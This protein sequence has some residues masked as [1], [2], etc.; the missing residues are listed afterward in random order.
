MT[1]TGM[2]AAQLLVG[3]A[4]T[5]VDPVTPGDSEFDCGARIRIPSAVSILRRSSGSVVEGVVAPLVV[6][7]LTLRWIDLRVA[8]LTTLVWSYLAVGRR[9]LKGE[10]VTFLLGLGTAMLTLRT[11]VSVVTNNAFVYFALPAVCSFG[12]GAY[13]SV[14]AVR[15][16][17]ATRRFV[18]DLC[19]LDEEVL[20]SSAVRRFM[21]RVSYLWAAALVIEATASMWLLLS[22]PVATFLIERTLVTWVITGLSAAGSAWMFQG[23]LRRNVSPCANGAHTGPHRR[24][25]M[26]LAGKR[27]NSHQDST[28]SDCHS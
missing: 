23:A 10:S 3:C 6:F 14:T 17:P 19:P 1:E 18:L 28:W 24:V 12:V 5:G 7:W 16:H 20:A 26:R 25:P 2:D 21:V 11:L 8:L 15:G 13:L 4:N 27:G 22:K 9:V